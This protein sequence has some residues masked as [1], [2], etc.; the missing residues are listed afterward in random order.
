MKKCTIRVKTTGKVNGEGNTMN[1]GKNGVH[2][3]RGE[4]SEGKVEVRNSLA[5]VA[6]TVKK[7][8]PTKKLNQPRAT[9]RKR[10]EPVRDNGKR[11]RQIK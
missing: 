2:T 9:N 7:E 8:E 1:K 4:E 6:A 11:R 5:D 3:R 10:M